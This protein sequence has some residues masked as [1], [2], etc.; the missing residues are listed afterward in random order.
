MQNEQK[1]NQLVL[2]LNETYNTYLSILF[3]SRTI[4]FRETEC[5][6]LPVCTLKKIQELKKKKNQTIVNNPLTDQFIYLYSIYV[7]NHDICD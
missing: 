7:Y 2:V 1:I 6:F 3:I 4:P 5:D